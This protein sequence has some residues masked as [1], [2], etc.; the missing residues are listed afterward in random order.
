M[1]MP[2]SWSRRHWWRTLCG[3][4]ALLQT[5]SGHAGGGA[6]TRRALA[7]PG[8]HGSHPDV[9]TEWWYLTGW[10]RDEGAQLLGFQVTFFRSRVDGA[11]GLRSRLAARQLL[12]AHAALSDP[13]Q[14][15]FVHEQTVAR[16]NG[17]PDEVVAGPESATGAQRADTR[18]RLPGWQ[19]NRLADGRYQVQLRQGELAMDLMGRPTQSLLL[20]G[21][22][23]WSRKGPDPAQASFYYS[24][25]QIEV[26][27][28][29]SVR[30]Q[31]RRVTGRAWLDHEWSEA[32]LHPEAVGWDWIGIHLQDG[33]ALTA[34][35]LRRADG[36]TL[37]AGGS[38]RSA[39]RASHPLPERVFGPKEV[40]FMAERHWESPR[41]G[42]RYPVDWR[43]HTPVG[44]FRVHALLDDQ[45]LDSRRTTGAIYWEGL[46][47]LRREG[48]AQP[49]G[50]GYL[51]LT[52]YGERL[53]LS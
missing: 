21:D 22:R 18:V 4:S 35:R 2:R 46:V 23:G 13:G 11:Q 29:V 33:S 31:A 16:W 36:Q 27:G 20:Q 14:G 45:E 41:T 42:T 7:F 53:H 28:L 6:L 32:L 44:V 48:D 51:E 12:F 47:E 37:W 9:R 17:G 1:S 25:P 5:P 19:L 52:G 49:A 39:R 8:D 50:L 34:F 38:F 15:R 26:Q 30:G 40:V 24:Q 43:V 3:L 10:L